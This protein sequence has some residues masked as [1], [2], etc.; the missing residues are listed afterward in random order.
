LADPTYNI[1]PPKNKEEW[2]VV[3]KLLLAYK[4]E[5]NDDTC[6]TSFEEELANIEQYYAGKDRL[7]LIAIDENNGTIAGCVAFKTFAPDVCEMKRLYVDPLHRGHQLGRK[8]AEAVITN[9][10]NQGF[11]QMILD[12][13]I[14]M[15]AAQ[16]LYHRLGF[17][18]IAPYHHQNEDKLICFSKDL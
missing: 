7:K 9:A 17:I 14:E 2:D 16:Q 15:R 13:M 6:F 12:T 10:A 3:K 11:K 1:R 18:I 4:H 8:L 5:F